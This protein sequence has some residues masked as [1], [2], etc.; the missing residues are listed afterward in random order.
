MAIGQDSD[1]T[2]SSS[3]I[4]GNESPL[5]THYSWGGAICTWASR[6]TVTNSIVHGNRAINGPA[7]A[8]LSPPKGDYYPPTEFT[9]SRSLVQD[10][11]PGVFIEDPWD[12]NAFLTWSPDNFEAD[13]A[14]VDPLG[15]DGFPRTGDEDLHLAPGSP[16]IDAG[17]PAHVA[18]PGAKDIDGDPRVLDGNGDG[19]AVIDIGAD[20]FTP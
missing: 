19:H 10:G 3:T 16:C 5:Y 17:D 6:V 7:F 12:G 4:V 13:P 20:E 9:I 14:I 15:P 2:V 18:T 1:V 11:Q 8:L